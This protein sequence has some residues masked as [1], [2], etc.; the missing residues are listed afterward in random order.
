MILDNFSAHK[1]WRIRH[2]A[3]K[4]KVEL[5][6]TPISAS[7]ANT[8]EAHFG[9]GQ[10]TLADSHHPNH[11][12]QTRELHR[13]LCWRNQPAWHPEVLAAQ[14]RERARACSEKGIRF[15][16]RPITAAA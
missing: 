7:W 9:R 1:N 2:W 14:R 13:F 10:F 15:D 12:I 6:F 16:G 8:T 5:C 4:N 3:A 11:T